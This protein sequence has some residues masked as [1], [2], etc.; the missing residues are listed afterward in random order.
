M[1]RVRAIDNPL[2]EHR[3][4]LGRMAACN[5]PVVNPICA[6]FTNVLIRDAVCGV[7]KRILQSDELI[8]TL[9]QEIEQLT[10]VIGFEPITM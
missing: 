2:G 6:L 3:R 8:P 5:G 10:N 7:P 9:A 4:V 1:Q